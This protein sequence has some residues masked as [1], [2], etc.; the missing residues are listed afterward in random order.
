M[1][2]LHTKIE[3]AT[4]SLVNIVEKQENVVAAIADLDALVAAHK[5]QLAPQFAHYLERRSYGKA[6]A[7]CR[8]GEVLKPAGP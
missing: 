3:Q 1:N 5:G 7:A 4:Q 8:S 6:L 2:A